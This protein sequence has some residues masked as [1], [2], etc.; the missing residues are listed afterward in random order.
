MSD[1]IFLSN[2]YELNEV[3]FDINQYY[4]SYKLQ[5]LC[6]NETGY[7]YF[8]SFDV[9]ITD[10]NMSVQDNSNQNFKIFPN[11]T[12]GLINLSSQSLSM[13]S[14]D[15]FTIEGKLKKSYKNHSTEN[16]DFSYLENGV[17]FIRFYLNNK[18]VIR[19]IIKK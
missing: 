17:Y 10:I 4:D 8:D 18:V 6:G 14:F 2:N 7:Y 15:V 1:E 19:K 3:E 9:T 12:N 5:L 16:I 13:I 11:P